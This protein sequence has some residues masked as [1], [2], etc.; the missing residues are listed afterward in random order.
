MRLVDAVMVVMVL[1][2][3]SNSKTHLVVY[4]TD[5]TCGSGRLAGV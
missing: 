2:D 4:A 3:A 5:Y 1:V